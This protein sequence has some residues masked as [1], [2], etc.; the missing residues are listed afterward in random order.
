MLFIRLGLKSFCLIPSSS[1]ICC[2]TDKLF[3]FLMHAFD[4][5]VLLQKCIKKMMFFMFHVLIFMNYLPHLSI[6]EN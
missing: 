1:V 3:R 6:E 4:F 5:H 2:L